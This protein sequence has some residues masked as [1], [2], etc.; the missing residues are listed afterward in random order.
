MDARMTLPE[1]WKLA[2]L[3]RQ[4]LTF[5][6]T[7]RSRR[8][9]TQL[10]KLAKIA[11][12]EQRPSGAALV[13]PIGDVE[14]A[15]KD[16]ETIA[17]TD[18]ETIV[19]TDDGTIDEND[20]GTDAGTDAGMA[21]MVCMVELAQSIRR[22]EDQELVSSLITRLYE[23]S[24]F[25]AM[26][27]DRSE[28]PVRAAEDFSSMM[29]SSGC[30]NDMVKYHTLMG[31]KSFLLCGGHIGL[32]AL[33][34]L[35]AHGELDH[36]QELGLE[37]ATAIGALFHDD[38]ARKMCSLG[39]DLSYILK[40]N[41]TRQLPLDRVAGDMQWAVMSEWDGVVD[42]WAKYPCRCDDD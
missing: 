1:E 4:G 11:R 6:A 12:T 38:W 35:S 7:M 26:E 28:D 32:A 30:D 21:S 15:G 23:I 20:A 8:G 16:D 9:L 14:G 42:K 39:Q 29:E 18:D 36:R 24:L 40:D 25:Q 19:G 37:E 34:P 3:S 10:I 13:L 27:L 5:F 33:M 17:G 31:K 2:P 22:L 41:E